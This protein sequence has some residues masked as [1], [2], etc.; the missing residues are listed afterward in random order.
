MIYNGAMKTILV[1]DD[2]IS[3]YYSIKMILD[4]LGSNYKIIP[5]TSGSEAIEYLEN[6]T[7]DLIFLDIWMPSSSGLNLLDNI[8]DMGVDAPVIIV[9]AIN[10][11]EAAVSAF[12]RGAVDYITKPFNASDIKEK[13][14]RYLEKTDG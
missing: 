6:N 7:A 1:I 3:I 4:E 12:K 11:A 14:I 10:L 2:D 8:K 13:T 9:S 5:F